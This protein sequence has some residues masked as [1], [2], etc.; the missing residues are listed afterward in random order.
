ML[1][2]DLHMLF[3]GPGMPIKKPLF[4][5]DGYGTK[6]VLHAVLKGC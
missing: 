3:S 1:S 4:K 6:R 5:N 2:P